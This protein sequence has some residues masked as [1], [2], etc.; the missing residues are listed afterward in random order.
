MSAKT[1]MTLEEFSQMTTSETED[2]ELVE[3]ELVPLASGNPMHADI[4]GVLEQLLR[5]YFDRS[6]IGRV[7]AEVDCRINDELV[8]R[9]DL[10]VF[11]A[12]R[13]KE[14]DRK[15]TP[16]PFA[17]D[18]AV[19]VLSPSE[20]AIEVHRKALEYLAG[21]TLEVWQLDHENGEIFVQTDSGITLLRGATAVLE[22][23]L[24][25]GFSASVAT[26]LAG[27]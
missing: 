20:N 17:P 26:L 12:N 16:L 22:T 15:K 8:R 14:I 3:G 4:R 9:P 5:N 6:R 21:G 11:L 1:L 18:I 7:L 10:S 13:L 24:L 19:E 25:P 27:F 23:P 2:Y